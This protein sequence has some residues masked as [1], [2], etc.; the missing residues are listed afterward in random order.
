[1][2]ALLLVGPLLFAAPAQAEVRVAPLSRIVQQISGVRGADVLCAVSPIEWRTLTGRNRDGG[3][4]I[5]G[6]NRVHLSSGT[7]RTL[8]KARSLGYERVG[9]KR[10]SAALFI[11]VHE[12]AHVRGIFHETAAD[13]R[14]LEDI[15][16]VANRHFKVFMRE[17][18]DL[19]SVNAHLIHLSSPPDYRTRPCN[20]LD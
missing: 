12:A 14:A 10:F 9:L 3:F 5:Q 4:V 20:E 15:K 1:M 18:L 11:L 17:Q 13:C 16:W 8:L 2:A 6:T 19:I 7:C